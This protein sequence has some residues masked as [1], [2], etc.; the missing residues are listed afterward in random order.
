VQTVIKVYVTVHTNLPTPAGSGNSG[1]ELGGSS[2]G[3]HKKTDP[4]TTLRNH[5][6]QI[7]WQYCIS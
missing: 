6:R 5:F 4:W 1:Q 3:S 2:W 7:F